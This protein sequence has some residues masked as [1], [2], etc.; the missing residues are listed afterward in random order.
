MF[1]SRAAGVMNLSLIEK[2]NLSVRHSSLMFFFLCGRHFLKI[3]LILFRDF[4]PPKMPLFTHAC[5]VIRLDTI[6]K[7]LF[8]VGFYGESRGR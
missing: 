5:Y 6:I 2:G 4:F 7:L 3:N 8:P 1:I